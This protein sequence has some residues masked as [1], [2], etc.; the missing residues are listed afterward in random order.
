MKQNRRSN[1]NI[2][3]LKQA[4]A[5]MITGGKEPSLMK[6]LLVARLAE[7]LKYDD[8]FSLLSYFVKYEQ[9]LIQ[10]KDELGMMCVSYYQSK[11][12]SVTD[13]TNIS[14]FLY[15]VNKDGTY[16][17][18]KIN[19]ETKECVKAEELARRLMVDATNDFKKLSASTLSFH[20]IKPEDEVNVV[21]L[22]KEIGLMV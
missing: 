4:Y 1:K 6:K 22:V 14:Y 16:K 11:T 10:D 3:P 13:N 19:K 21:K 7:E 5:N 20:G 9:E 2:Q 12:H 18:I 8:L 17:A 15:N